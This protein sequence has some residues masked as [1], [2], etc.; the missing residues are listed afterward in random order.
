MTIDWHFFELV[1]SRFILV[2]IGNFLTATAI[3]CLKRRTSF[4]FSRGYIGFVAIGLVPI[5]LNPFV[6]GINGRLS[7]LAVVLAAV[8]AWLLYRLLKLDGDWL[9][10]NINHDVL[11]D[12][13]ERTLEEMGITYERHGPKL[14]LGDTDASIAILYQPVMRYA[15]VDL[16][17]ESA[18]EVHHALEQHVREQLVNHEVTPMYFEGGLFLTIGLVCLLGAITY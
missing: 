4:E 7:V 15:L 5:I 8:S 10:F 3:L 11:D 6:I 12:M 16:E 9:I 13:M 2:Y 1:L 14:V 17:L 18:P